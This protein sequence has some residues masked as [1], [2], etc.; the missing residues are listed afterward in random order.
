MTSGA[1]ILLMVTEID[2]EKLRREE[3][4]YAC[5]AYLDFPQFRRFQKCITP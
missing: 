2:K 4:P 3:T 1:A 5:S